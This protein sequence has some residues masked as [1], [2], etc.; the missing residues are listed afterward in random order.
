M[1]GTRAV[2]ILGSTGEWSG[3]GTRALGAYVHWVLGSTAILE[4][5][6]DH[7]GRGEPWSVKVLG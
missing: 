5:M 3:E 4:F 6:G 2:C 7:E 1:V